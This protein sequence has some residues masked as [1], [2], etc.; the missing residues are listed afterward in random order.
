LVRGHALA[1]RSGDFNNDGDLDVVFINGSL[2][3][4][5]VMFGDGD[6]TFTNE[7]RFEVPKFSP[8]QVI[9]LDADLDGDLDIV[10]VAYSISEGSS[11]FLYENQLDP[12]GF[13]S[14]SFEITG[15]DN[16]ELELASASGKVFNRIKNSMSSGDYYR[17]NLDQNSQ[18]DD[19]ASVSVVESGAYSL[20]VTPKPNLPPGE[21]FSLEFSLNGE[22]YRLAE[23]IPMNAAGYEFTVYPSGSSEVLPVPGKF[24]YNNPPNFLWQ[25]SGDFD[26]ELASDIDFASLLISASI[27]TNS[28]TPDSTLEVVDTATFYW[29]VKP[30]G[31]A[32][33]DQFY[34]INLIAGGAAACGDIDGSGTGP[35][36][37]DLTYFVDYL[38]RNGPPPPIPSQADIDGDPG[39]NIGD[40]SYLVAFLFRGGA[41]PIC[42]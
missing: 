18:L 15:K 4:M 2:N 21:N 5:A 3:Y 25:G 20:T 7:I 23:D 19:F 24:I 29:R 40:L 38:F 36:V 11:L 31:A 33:Y 9:C 37:A 12:T 16:A 14:V 27:S 13:N 6:G 8:R 41:P 1:N 32:Q 35:N 10:V 39:I 22:S 28:Y 34:V 30:S 42:Q 26:F 17:R